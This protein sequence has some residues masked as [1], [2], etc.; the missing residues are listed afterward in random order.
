ML[1]NPNSV[2]V[3][4]ADIRRFRKDGRSLISMMR[5]SGIKRDERDKMRVFLANA[6]YSMK[7]N[8]KGMFKEMTRGAH[9]TF[10]NQFG[11]ETFGVYNPDR[12]PISTYTKM[13]QDSQVALGLAVIKMPLEGL[14]RTVECEDKDVAEF[15]DEAL[16]MIWTR[17][18]KSMLTS[19]DYGFASHEKVWWLYP[20]DVY[21]VSGTGRRKTHFKGMGEVYKKVKAHYPE[22]IRI[23]VDKKTGDFLG[24]VQDIGGGEPPVPLDKDKCFFFAQE[25]EFGNYY[26][27]SRLKQAYKPWYWKE[28]M[29]QF[30]LRYFE[31]RGSPPTTVTF[32]PGINQDA[33]GNEVDNAEI[34]LQIGQ[35]LIE[36]SVVTL[37]YEETKDGRDTMWKVKYLEDDQRGPM[38]IEC[39]NHLETQI[40]RGLLVPERVVTQDIATGSYSMAA[41]HAEAFLLAQEGLINNMES[42]INHQIV[43]PL[44]QFNFKPKSWLSCKVHIEEVQHDRKR[45]LKEIYI[46]IIRNLTT[47]ARAGKVP[48]VLPSLSEMASILKIPTARFE[49]EY[50]TIPVD[51]TAG[52]NGG[53]VNNP[54]SKGDDLPENLDVKKKKTNGKGKVVP[55]RRKAALIKRTPVV[56]E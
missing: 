45:L 4:P 30:M 33:A 34:A 14:S 51:G 11:M 36:N 9:P 38:F 25:D 53:G 43:P 46:E 27:G 42:A 44:V 18:I 15:V 32:P 29:Y 50:L 55:I 49:E 39:I 28:I 23:R 41:S 16:S 10:M 20:M 40:L 26:G 21:S 52:G 47:L 1:R 37:P 22:T 17:L 56:L 6:E 5:N 48:N 8:R 54:P 35:S 24:I 19:V 13:K 12:I 2:A 7:V 3:T 31:R